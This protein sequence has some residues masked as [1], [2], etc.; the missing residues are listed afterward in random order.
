MCSLL[1]L[2]ADTLELGLHGELLVQHIRNVATAERV[3]CTREK[4]K[5]VGH[6]RRAT[7]SRRAMAIFGARWVCTKPVAG[8]RCPQTFVVTVLDARLLVSFSLI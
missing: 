6:G 3:E 2:H 7:G 8:A 5:W 4:S 1:E